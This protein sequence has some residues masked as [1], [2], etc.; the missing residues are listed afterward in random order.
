MHVV[1]GGLVPYMGEMIAI[2]A[3]FE[4]GWLAFGVIFPHSIWG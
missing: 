1:P 3:N 4:G 2:L